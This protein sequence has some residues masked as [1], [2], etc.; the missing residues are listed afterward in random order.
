MFAA[1]AGGVRRAGG[2]L[3][4]SETPP[5]KRPSGRVLN[6][7]VQRHLGVFQLDYGRFGGV[8]GARIVG[9]VIDHLGVEDLVVEDLLRQLFGRQA[10]VRP[11]PSAHPG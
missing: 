8:L 2:N 11:A 10:R 6:S 4:S 1:K 7:V 5:Q 9:R 3:A